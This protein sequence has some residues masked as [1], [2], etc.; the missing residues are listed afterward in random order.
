MI[1]VAPWTCQTPPRCLPCQ[2]DLTLNL[3]HS[4]HTQCLPSRSTPA[5]LA[6]FL[7]S[8]NPAQLPCARESPDLAS[9]LALIWLAV[10]PRAYIAFRAHCPLCTKWKSA[11]LGKGISLGM[12]L[13]LSLSLAWQNSQCS[14]EKGREDQA[15]GPFEK[16]SAFCG[17]VWVWLPPARV[18]GKPFNQ[19]KENKMSSMDFVWRPSVLLAGLTFFPRCSWNRPRPNPE[20]GGKFQGKLAPS[21]AQLM[22]P[23]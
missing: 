21:L 9:G 15:S 5:W 10:W 18:K 2:S 19:M 20:G 22:F 16:Y 23:Q 12:I 4:G 3:V 8:T 1:P 14:W 13:Q 11:G 7:R 6:P 17:N